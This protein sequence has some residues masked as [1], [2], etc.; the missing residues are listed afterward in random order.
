MSINNKIHETQTRI[1]RELLFL[2]SARFAELQK[3]NRA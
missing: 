1:L 2:P 3:N